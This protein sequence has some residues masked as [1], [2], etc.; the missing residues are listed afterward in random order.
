[1]QRNEKGADLSRSPLTCDYSSLQFC[2]ILSSYNAT[3]GSGSPASL[4]FIYTGP[5]GIYYVTQICPTGIY[6]SIQYIN[7]I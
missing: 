5:S 3:F 4:P 7:S 2:M 6:G 1:M